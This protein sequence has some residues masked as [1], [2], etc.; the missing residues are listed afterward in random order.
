MVCP[1]CGKSSV[2]YAPD[3]NIVDQTRGEEEFYF[4]RPNGD[5]PRF[6]EP[7]NCPLKN[8]R[9]AGSES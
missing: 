3:D 9:Q 4:F 1:E 2:I 6:C 5:M 7:N 8:K